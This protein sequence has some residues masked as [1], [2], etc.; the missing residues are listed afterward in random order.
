MIKLSII[1]YKY[2]VNC[3]FIYLSIIL[4]FI[5]YLTEKKGKATFTVAFPFKFN[6]P[7]LKGHLLVNLIPKLL[8]RGA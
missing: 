2:L 4:N 6:L 7:L 3:I 1:M 8:T 5:L